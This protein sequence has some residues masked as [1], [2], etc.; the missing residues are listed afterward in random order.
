MAVRAAIGASRRRLIRQLAAE[1][2]LLGAAGCAFGVI[3]AYLGAPALLSLI[4][5]DLPTWMNFSVD[6]RVLIFA[7]GIALL[8]A[9]G[10]GVF[11][12]VSSTRRDLTLDLREGGR[13]R[14]S[15]RGQKAVRRTLIVTELALS[16]ALL[17]G[18]G[19][20]V[21]SFR[22]LISQNLGYAPQKLLSLY[23]N[24]PNR[25]YPDGPKARA[26]VNGLIEKMAALPGV[27]SVAAMT[28]PPL[29]ATWTRIF[30]IGGRPL[31]LKDMP[32]VSHL[33]VTAGYFRTLQLPLLQGRDFNEDDYDAPN[34]LVVSQ[35]FAARYWPHESAI[36]KSVRFGPPKNQEPWHTVIGVVADTKM[37]G[38]QQA[39]SATVYLPYS[40]E[41]TPAT[42]LV[43][44]STD[45]LQLAPALRALITGVDRSISVSRVLTLEQ[46]REQVSWRERFFSVLMTCFTGIALLLAAVGF[47][48]ML[49]Y[50]V[51][52]QRREIGVR[53]ALGASYSNVLRLVMSEGLR[54]IGIGLAAG[55]LLAAGLTRLLQSQIFEVS[56][57][58]PVAWIAAVLVLI[59]VAALAMF[60]P[61][62]KAL[63]VDP[64]VALREQ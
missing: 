38:L 33:V 23:I 52:L 7:L 11:P 41:I 58:D 37:R 20:M 63:R 53:I 44:A 10:A 54:L 22:V 46:I 60:G 55:A 31:P 25:S 24:Y 62:R 12:M 39:E 59:L 40:P 28:E 56:P 21:H 61:V 13:G 6:A 45:P 64:V 50:S 30:T 8:T 9:L 36:G 51:S 47:Y 15:S 43:R 42:F 16:M 35:S 3:L 49:S 1:S 2:L 29:E 57:M 27:I 48:A 32:F 19:V 17:V 34:V 4:P 5:V 14:S 26:L 18:A